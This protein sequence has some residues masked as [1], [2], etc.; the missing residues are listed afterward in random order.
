MPQR[1]ATGT[2][3]VLVVECVKCKHR[4]CKKIQLCVG[5][6]KFMYVDKIAEGTPSSSK[7]SYTASIIWNVVESSSVEELLIYF[8]MHSASTSLLGWKL[9]ILIS[10]DTT[11]FK[12]VIGLINK[13]TLAH[14]ESW[15]I[16]FR[17]G[18]VFHGVSIC[19]QNANITSSQ[20]YFVLYPQ[21]TY[22][23]LSVNHSEII[24]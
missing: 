12:A 19:K 23:I 20:F 24:L 18:T 3:V 21:Y 1:V 9:E 4:V 6:L 5:S 13:C 11:I 15:A 16:I 7:C 10:K 22:T 8:Q 14:T 17:R 2:S